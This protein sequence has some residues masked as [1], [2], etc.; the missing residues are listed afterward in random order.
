MQ[1]PA[2]AEDGEVCF[3]I[4]SLPARVLLPDVLSESLDQSPNLRSRVQ[5]RSIEALWNRLIAG[6]IEFFISAEGRL[7]AAPLARISRL[8]SFQRP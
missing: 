5:I 3:G 2:D 4:E 7:P 8:G 6:E 1:R